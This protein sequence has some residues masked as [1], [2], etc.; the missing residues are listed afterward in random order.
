M[1]G[2]NSSGDRERREREQDHQMMQ[3]E[4]G[5][6]RSGRKNR[7]YLKELT[8]HN[9]DPA[10]ERLM[11]NLL[12]PDFVLG[13]LKDPEVNEVRWLARVTALAI[14][15][16]HP[17]EGSAYTGEARKYYLD[18][19]YALKPLSDHEINQIN[20]ALLAYFLRIT[21][22]RDGWQQDQI[23]QQMK[24]SK[25]EEDDEDSGYGGLFS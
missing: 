16:M 1:I 19:E 5:A 14:Q 7:E 11:Q 20:Q 3:S 6:S 13:N 15:R 9:L 2:S 22:S 21:R 25:R 24:V 12:G 8:K 23:S 18:T 4:M 17:P 10:T